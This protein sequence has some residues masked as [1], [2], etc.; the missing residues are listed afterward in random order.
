MTAMSRPDLIAELGELRERVDGCRGAAR[1]IVEGLD[2]AQFNARP[3]PDSWSVCECLHHLV[4][5]G[6][7]VG[8]AIDLALE[9]AHREGRLS[10]GPFRYGRL[11][12]WFVRQ[13]N[14]DNFPKRRRVKTVKTYEPQAH[15]SV[16]N[17][18]SAFDA[19]QTN[20]IERIEAS[21]GIDLA[22]VR[23]TSPATRLIRL[24][25]G[26]WLEL[27]VGHQERHLLQ[28]REA[29]SAVGG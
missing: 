8:H 7:K 16:T 18:L 17:V 24:S 1:E 5:T 4:V 25:L 22:R 20:L 14:A 6:E 23:I 3:T 9:R 19:L 12:N 11:G 13:C 28:A 15:Q 10:R 27:L 2:D 26:Q 21:N 29:R